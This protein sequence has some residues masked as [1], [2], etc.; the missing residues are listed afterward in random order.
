MLCND[1]IWPSLI[2]RA[3]FAEAQDSGC[4]RPSVASPQRKVACIPMLLINMLCQRSWYHGNLS[5]FLGGK[6]VL[7]Q[8]AIG[9]L[10]APGRL[11]SADTVSPMDGMARIIIKHHPVS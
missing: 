4:L 1:V 7:R 11:I 5:R 2:G 10:L 9:W 6:V 8:V 3:H